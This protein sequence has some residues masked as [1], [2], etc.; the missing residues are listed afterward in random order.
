M[1]KLLF[2]IIVIFL[3]SALFAQKKTNYEKYWQAREDSI[4]KSEASV[5]TMNSAVSDT[6]IQNIEINNYYSDDPFYYSNYIGRFYHGGFNYWMYSDPWYYD[7]FYFGYPYWGYSYWGYNGFW[8]NPWNYGYGGRYENNNHQN[9]SSGRYIEGFGVSKHGSTQFFSNRNAQNR[10]I[11]PQNKPEYSKSNRSYSPTYQQPHM[12]MKP[13]FNNSRINNGN[14]SHDQNSFQSKRSENN[15]TQRSLQ[16]P[17]QARTYSPPSQ[18][19]SYNSTQN[20]S[21]G[22][23]SRNFNSGESRSSGSYNNGSSSS[24]RSSSGGFSGSSSGSSKSG[25][26]GRR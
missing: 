5:D 10:Q 21:Y 9:Y 11:S 18:P 19:R 25:G 22:G 24:S 13:V 1:K 7:N 6:I 12:N 16:R 3:T 2:S 23:E 8:I 15:N 14:R 20:R 26:S 17:S 4:K